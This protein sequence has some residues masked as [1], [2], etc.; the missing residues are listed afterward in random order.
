MGK[1][2]GL[3]EEKRQFA[4]LID[5]DNVSAKYAQVIF[6]ELDKYGYASCRRI[7]GNW[8]KGSDWTEKKLLDYSIMPIQQFNYTTGKNAADMAMVIDAMDLL[9]KDKVDGFCLVTSDS[10]F[11]R[12]AMRL[13]EEQK[14][15]LGMGESKTPQALK[16]AC[17]KFVLLNLVGE[18]EKELTGN[19]EHMAQGADMDN[20]TRIEDVEKTIEMMFLE[21]GT[22]LMDLG[23]VGNRLAEKFTDFDARNYGYSKLSVFLNEEM[24]HYRV[25]KNNNHYCLEKEEEQVSRKEIE[26]EIYTFIRKNGGSIDNLSIIHDELKR[27]YRNFSVSNY[28]YKAM[29]KFLRSIQGLNVNANTVKIKKNEK[30]RMEHEQV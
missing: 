23:Y 11:T 3:A 6:D 22:N 1:E 17:N 5:S 29:S 18:S 15:V 7:Y 20:V 12:L 8:S 10:D 25:R 4:V 30:K 27:K 24:K 26:E 28:G 19:S 21:Q 13:R 9:Y 14:Y 2:T 16:K